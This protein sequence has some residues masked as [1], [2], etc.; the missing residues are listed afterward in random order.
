MRILFLV[1]ILFA[2]SLSAQKAEPF[3]Q[4]PLN[5]RGHYGIP[6]LWNSEKVR[7]GYELIPSK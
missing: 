7:Q 4:T 6:D 3:N 5:T 2:I 1:L